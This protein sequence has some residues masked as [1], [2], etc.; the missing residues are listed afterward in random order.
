MPVC[1]FLLLFITF[2]NICGGIIMCL[3]ANGIYLIWFDLIEI[4]LDYVD[5]DVRLF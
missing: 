4:E 5:G 3:C 1:L 2:G